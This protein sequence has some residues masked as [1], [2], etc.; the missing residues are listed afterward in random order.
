MT[1][2]LAVLAASLAAPG[3]PQTLFAA[4]E[5]ETQA[6]V[7]HKLFTLL[8]VDGA[9]VA[10]I[11]SNRPGEYPVSGRKTMGAT[12]WGKH[13]LEE[14]RPYLGRDREAIRWA[15]FDHELIGSM[16]L[17]SVINVPVI[18]DGTTIGTMNLLDAEH[19]YRAEHV[20]PVA[21]LAPLLVPAFL[22]A[23]AGL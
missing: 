22:A 1:D 20:A 15:F 11:Y 16:G 5:R 23:R 8:F 19:H 10:R 4:L 6:L 13:V 18:Y 12:P 7:G 21:R 14:Q 3:Q 17:G 9:D 2:P